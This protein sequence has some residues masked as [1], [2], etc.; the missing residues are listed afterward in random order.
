M[1]EFR[2]PIGGGFSVSG[3]DWLKIDWSRDGEGKKTIHVIME[4]VSL[5]PY[6]RQTYRSRFRRDRWGERC[7]TY[8]D[9]Q[10]MFRDALNLK[11]KEMGEYGNMGY[12]KQKLGLSVLIDMKEKGRLAVCDLGN[13]VKAVEDFCNKSVMSDDRQVYRYGICEKRLAVQD[14]IELFVF[15]L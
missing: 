11:L 4:G 2:E 15:E 12:D 7:R 6:V 8:N 10:A 9:Q 14:R 5:Q 13:L 1:S 3:L